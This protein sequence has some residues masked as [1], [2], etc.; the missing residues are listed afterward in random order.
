MFDGDDFRGS[1]EEDLFYQ[2]TFGS[3]LLKGRRHKYLIASEVIEDIRAIAAKG[4]MR[5]DSDEVYID[6]KWED[7]FKVV[8]VGPLPIDCR[9]E[10]TSRDEQIKR[11]M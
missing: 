1:V 8:Q 5:V 10:F 7:I 9:L 4:G 11:E 3:K 6:E 2:A